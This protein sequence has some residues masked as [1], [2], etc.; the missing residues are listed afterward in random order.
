MG[1]EISYADGNYLF[2]TSGKK[3]LDLIAGISVSNVGHRNQD[4][5]TAIKNQADQHLH[6]LV[7]GEHIQQPQVLLAEA[8]VKTL[9]EPLT[10]IC[11]VNSGSEA[12]EGAMKLVKRV[13]GRFEILGCKNAYHG[14]SQGALSLNG[15]EYYKR[16]FRPLLPGIRQIHFGNFDDLN[17]INQKTAGVFVETV[18]GE[19]GVRKA[20]PLYFKALRQKCTDT[21]TLLVLDEI[22]TGFGR[23]GTFWGFAQYG[24]V[25]DIIVMSKGMGG[26]MPIG[27]FAASEQ[28]L[29]KFTFDPVL[30]HISTFG[31][32]PVSCAASL[33]TMKF[34]ENH[35]L[36]EQVKAK[37]TQFLD[38]LVH[39]SI[40]EIRST[41]L[42]MGVE[43][44]S[45]D[46]VLQTIRL[47][48]DMGVISDWFLHCNTALRIAPPL[49]IR[50]EEIKSACDVIVAALNK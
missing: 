7:Y 41:G 48:L 33:A 22:Q 46:K 15:D 13:T 49:T 44:G 3:Y 6:T 8:L 12:I 32:H 42:L 19:A 20:D 40:L 34:L 10:Q 26:G 5:I 29:H 45:F 31:G 43:L 1:L 24:I 36:I 39:D 47:C 4:I 30:G 18:Q 11:F 38:Q 14:S 50:P 25:P 35:L 21:G 37:E 9:P 28:H 16:N 2:D 23:T 27:A 17:R